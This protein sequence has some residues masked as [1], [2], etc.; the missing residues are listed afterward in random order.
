MNTFIILLLSL[1]AV[2]VIRQAFIKIKDISP[3]IVLKIFAAML[4]VIGIVRY[5]MSDSFVETVGPME[6]PLQTFLRWSYHIGYAVIPMSVFFD[7]RLFRNIASYFCLPVSILSAFFFNDTFAYF[8]AEGAGGFYVDQS[9]RSLF[10]TLELILAIII[11]ALMQIHH[12]HIINVKN[13]KELP[14]TIGLIPLIMLQMMPS[15]ML[16]TI[17]EDFDLTTGMFGQLH[18]LWLGALLVEILILNFIFRKRSEKDKFTLIAFLVLAQVMHTM[19]SFVRGFTFSRIPLQLCNIAAFFYLYMII[20]KDK[21]MFDFCYLANLVGAVIAM[22]LVNFTSDS[23]NFWNLHYIY[24]HSFVV[25]VPVLCTTLGIFKRLDKRAIKHMLSI[26]SVYF[27]FVFVFG[28]IINAID[29]NPG[30]AVNHFY[31]FNPVVAVQYLPFAGFTG[32]IHWQFGE[33]EIYPILVVIIFILFSVINFGFLG[34]NLL[35]Y[36]I[37]DKIKARKNSKTDMATV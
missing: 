21:R 12:K 2:F 18:L 14:L 19:S 15:Y 20:K 32:L 36:K 29:T 10:Y 26:F 11:P 37:I 16:K 34:L 24:E 27:A 9:F 25:M 4:P 1:V 3:D 28:T 13:V 22:V 23:F 17:V 33:F 35:G 8:V 5:F 6:D 30:Y 7:N 31:M